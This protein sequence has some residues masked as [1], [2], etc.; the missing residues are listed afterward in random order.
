M[1]GGPL[2]IAIPS[3]ALSISLTCSCILS[4][5]PRSASVFRIGF[6]GSMRI[7]TRSPSACAGSELQDP[8]AIKS[9]RQFAAL[10]RTSI[11]GIEQAESL[12]NGQHAIIPVG[13]SMGGMA[14][15]KTINA[16]A[17]RHALS[18]IVQH[19]LVGTVLESLREHDDRRR[20]LFDLP[21]GQQQTC[22]CWRSFTNGLNSSGGKTI[23]VVVALFSWPCLGF[24]DHWHFPMVCLVTLQFMERRL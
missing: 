16:E 5:I 7:C 20:I 14:S 18:R 21:A 8:V 3:L 15:H 2:M 11:S 6:L 22:C 12:Q 17:D 1:G 4:R 23:S 10:T 13:R 24:R 9:E 19:D